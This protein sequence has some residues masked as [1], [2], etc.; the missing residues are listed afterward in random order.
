MKKGLSYVAVV[1][2]RSGSMNSNQSD[3]IGGFN[4]FLKSQQEVEGDALF[5]LAQFDNEYLVNY[6]SVDIKNVAPLDN[7]TY[8]PRGWTALYDAIGRTINEVGANLAKLPESERPETVSFVVLTDGLENCSREFTQQQVFD[9]IKHQT[10][11]Y[12][13]NFIYLGANQDG[14]AVGG[15]LGFRQDTSATYS[16]SNSRGAFAAASNSTRLYRK[17]KTLAA[18]NFSAEVRSCLANDEN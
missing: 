7:T 2:D 5:T 17:A 12:N 4:T 13:W 18:A 16:A 6:S 3:T 14:M 11:R 9:M 1:L 15:S 8:V 10:E